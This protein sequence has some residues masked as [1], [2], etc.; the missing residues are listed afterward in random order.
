MKHVE[1]VS[2]SNG[3]IGTGLLER[4]PGATTTYIKTD[5][6]RGAAAGGGSD[7]HTFRSSS[8]AMDDPTAVDKF[9]ELLQMVGRRDGRGTRCVVLAVYLVVGDVD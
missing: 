6:P 9:V 1:Y 3:F 4:I 2:L 5:R 7:A 8:G